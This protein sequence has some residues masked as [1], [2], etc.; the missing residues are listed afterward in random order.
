MELYYCTKCGAILQEYSRLYN[1]NRHTGTKFVSSQMLA[2]PG[3]RPWMV[4]FGKF[5]PHDLIE[6]EYYENGMRKGITE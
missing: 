6:V 5:A 2:C 3:H 1:Y 4:F